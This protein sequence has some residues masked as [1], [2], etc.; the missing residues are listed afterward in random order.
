MKI[1]VILGSIRPGRATERV[2]K[3]AADEAAKLEG[4]EVEIVDLKD[5]PLPLFDEAASPQFNPDRKPEGVVKKWLDKL[6][7]VDAVIIASPEYNRSIPGPMKNALDYVAFEL[8]KKPVALVTHGSVGGAYAMADY[9]VALAQMHA[10]VVPEPT[11]IIGAAG[12]LEENGTLDPEAAANPYGPAG[13]LA[14]TLESLQWLHGALA[15]A[16]SGE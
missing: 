6:D 1:A 3:W 16:R 2:A 8:A 13:A 10:I 15:P 12:V 4:A 7:D 9:R 5:Y 11:M 14:T